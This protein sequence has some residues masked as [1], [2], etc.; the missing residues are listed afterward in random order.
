VDTVTQNQQT[1][2]R[3]VLTDSGQNV[4]DSSGYSDTEPTDG[5]VWGTDNFGQILE[6]CSGHSDTEPTDGAV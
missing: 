1:V 5:T 3:E 2:E 6:D 4:E